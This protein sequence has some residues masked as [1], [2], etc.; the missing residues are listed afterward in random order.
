MTAERSASR[1]GAGP[2]DSMAEGVVL[3]K[4]TV[5]RS[6]PFSLTRHAT[7][8]RNHVGRECVGLE[9][10]QDRD[11][12][13]QRSLEVRQLAPGTSRPVSARAVPDTKSRRRGDGRPLRTARLLLFPRSPFASGFQWLMCSAVGDRSRRRPRERSLRHVAPRDRPFVVPLDKA[14]RRPSARRPR[15]W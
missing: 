7:R 6:V 15:G 14:P 2:W 13:P 3:P 4:A 5:R 1:R 12:A 9:A 10:V 8:W 11:A